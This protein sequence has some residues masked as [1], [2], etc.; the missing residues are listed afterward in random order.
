MNSQYSDLHRKAE[1][2]EYKLRDKLD[3]K[4]SPIA[5]KLTTELRRFR[6]EVQSE[7]SARSLESMA[8]NIRSLLESAGRDDSVMDY[9]DIDFFEDEFEDIIMNLR[10][11]DNY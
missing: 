1:G 3:D 9:H 8:K 2:L 5:S 11:F 7:K 4:N 6:D 10:K